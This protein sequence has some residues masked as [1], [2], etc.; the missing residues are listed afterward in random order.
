MKK[1]KGEKGVNQMI[2]DEWEKVSAEEKER[3]K[4]KDQV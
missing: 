2:K 3:A 1:L 4:V